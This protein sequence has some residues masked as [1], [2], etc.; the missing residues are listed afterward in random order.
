MAR[1]LNETGI[2][3]TKR[4]SIGDDWQQIW[5]ALDEATTSA[6]LVLITGG[7]GPTADDITKPLLCEYFGGQLVVNQQALD[8]VVG[9]FE[10][11]NRDNPNNPRPLLER[12]KKQAEVPDVC[13]VLLN[14]S[15]TAPGM[16]FQKN[17]C[18]VISMPGVPHEEC[19]QTAVSLQKLQGMRIVP[20]F[21]SKVKQL[22]GGKQGCL[23]LTT[24]VLAM[25]PAILQGFWAFRNRHP[26]GRKISSELMDNY[27][28]DTCW[29]WRRDGPLVKRLK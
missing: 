5:R 22:L 11:I 1:V 27:L 20:G 17:G 19:A 8:N 3:V 15:G 13:E 12:N 18:T 2:A 16:L 28:L 24:L 14:S 7:L 6:E 10:R 25:A 26:E 21:T 29:V 4:I 23:H 9:I